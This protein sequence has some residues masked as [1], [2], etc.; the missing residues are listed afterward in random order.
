MLEDI[1]KLCLI[2]LI[3]FKKQLYMIFVNK[4]NLQLKLNCQNRD[5]ILYN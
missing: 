5:V 2:Y 4:T 1:L 3:N